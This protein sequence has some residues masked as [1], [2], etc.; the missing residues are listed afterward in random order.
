MSIRVHM[1]ACLYKYICVHVYTST[2]VSLC[3]HKTWFIIWHYLSIFVQ[4][5][6]ILTFWCYVYIG[7]DLDSIPA[8]IL[9]L[10]SVILWTRLKWLSVWCICVHLNV[11]MCVSVPVCVCVLNVWVCSQAIVIVLRASYLLHKVKKKNWLYMVVYS[12]YNEGVLT[13]GGAII[14]IIKVPWSRASCQSRTPPVDR[15]NP[16]QTYAQH[17]TH[18]EQRNGSQ[19]P[20]CT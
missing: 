4:C 19:H 14:R 11:C 15:D 13:E 8:S 10:S 1:C 17:G 20:A 3:V 6:G 2:Y 18:S 12:H 7:I 9:R 16:N 5:L